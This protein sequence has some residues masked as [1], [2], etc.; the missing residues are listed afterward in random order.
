M[1]CVNGHQMPIDEN[2]CR[3]CG[4]ACPTDVCSNGHGMLAGDSFCR[5]CGEPQEHKA[6]HLPSLQDVHDKGVDPET[7]GMEQP[8]A[9]P[10]YSETS[11]RHFGWASSLFRPRVAVFVG[12]VIVLLGG[13]AVGIAYM[14]RSEPS[15][16]PSAPPLTRTDA[17]A[18]IPSC[19]GCR[20]IDMVSGLSSRSGPASLVAVRLPDTRS[21]SD[22]SQVR[23]YLIGDSQQVIWRAPSGAPILSP[24]PTDGLHFT[25]DK[26]GNALMPIVEGA[27]G[28][29]I[30]IIRV[31]PD[32]INDFG[33]LTSGAFG[34][35]SDP[36]L[37]STPSGYEQI[38]LPINN[39]QPNYAQGTT[40]DNIYSWSTSTDAYVLTSCQVL[41]GQGVP[42]TGYSP[43]GRKC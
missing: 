10:A 23:F 32:G 15:T 21:Y 22:N 39:Y 31:T 36:Y 3:R 34:S 18:D 11:E 43:T 12:A 40:T 2:F 13:V 29:Q 24:A 41:N 38:V 4:Q 5:R 8:T 33:T 42:G 1:Y 6:L 17:L 9:V 30:L 35:N 16:K 20:I 25:V 26:S 19:G 7:V 37:Q 28:G 14:G 27:H